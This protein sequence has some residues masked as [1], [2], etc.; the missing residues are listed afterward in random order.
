MSANAA[1]AKKFNYPF[2]LLC[3]TAREI[4]LAYGA[5]DSPDAKT[6]KRISYLIGPEGKILRAYS[7][8]AAA[9]HPKQVLDDIVSAA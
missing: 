3:D 4:G 8:V 6:A 9:D 7:T 1:F 5:C 2:P